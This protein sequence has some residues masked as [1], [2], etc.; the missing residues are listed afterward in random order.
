[1]GRERGWP[2]EKICFSPMKNAFSGPTT[3]NECT[4]Q[5]LLGYFKNDID[6]FLKEV[7]ENTYIKTILE[8]AK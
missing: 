4:V 6:T 7:H 8:C 3:V 5:S 1:M 2:L